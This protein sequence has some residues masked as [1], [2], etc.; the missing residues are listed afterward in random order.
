M[1]GKC[2][3]FA[4]RENTLRPFLKKKRLNHEGND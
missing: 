3:Y 2:G 4:A 1:A